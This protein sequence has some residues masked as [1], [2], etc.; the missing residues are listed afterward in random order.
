MLDKDKHVRFFEYAGKDFSFFADPIL[1][2]S[3]ESI[4]GENLFVRRNGF[5]FYGYALSNWVYSLNFYDNEEAGNNLDII[6]DLTLQRGTSVTKIKEN[7]FEYDFVNASVGYYWS[8]GTISLGK[9]YFSIGS[10]RNGNVIINYQVIIILVLLFFTVYN[11]IDLRRAVLC[12][13][14]SGCYQWR[15]YY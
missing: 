5:S 7:V 3:K 1:N 2:L 6:K 11:F 4:A 10:G 8:N 15:F 9:E 14:L 13:T 12:G